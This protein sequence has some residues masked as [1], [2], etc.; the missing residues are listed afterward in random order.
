MSNDNVLPFSIED[1]RKKNILRDDDQPV[2]LAP[3]GPGEVML[4]VLSPDEQAVYNEMSRLSVEIEDMSRELNARYLELT[5]AAI[6]QSADPSK[7]Y[8]NLQRQWKN[9]FPTKEEAEAFFLAQTQFEYV[10]SHFNY[11][12]RSRLGYGAVYGV[13]SNY[14]VVRVN[15][16]Y[17]LPPEQPKHEDN[18]TSFDRKPDGSA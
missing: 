11:M 5:A 18:V 12:V 16:K 4:G 1:M 6:R 2:E 9:L 13:R 14:T 7:L 15:Y 10:Q 3:V 17:E 8:N